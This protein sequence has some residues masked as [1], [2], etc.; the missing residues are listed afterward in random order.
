[1]NPA[2][3][4][5][6]GTAVITRSVVGWRFIALATIRCSWRSRS[7]WR[8]FRRVGLAALVMR[9]VLGS[10]S[11]HLALPRAAAVVTEFGNAVPGGANAGPSACSIQVTPTSCDTARAQGP[12]KA[13]PAPLKTPSTASSGRHV[14]CQEQRLAGRSA[15]QT[16]RQRLEVAQA[17]RVALDV[18]DDPVLRHLAEVAVSLI[19]LR[20]RPLK[21]STICLANFTNWGTRCSVIRWGRGMP[22]TL[23]LLRAQVIRSARGAQGR[24]CAGARLLGGRGVRSFVPTGSAGSARGAPCL[25]DALPPLSPSSCLRTRRETP[26]RP[27]LLTLKGNEGPRSSAS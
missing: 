8:N 23:G 20:N 17:D 11:P 15:A 1:M 14:L 10:D 19:K 7:T 27:T 22:V 13:T 4:R 6:K 21:R 12:S 26:L 25:L 24:W 18:D 2:S 5:V 3:G 9:S 16:A